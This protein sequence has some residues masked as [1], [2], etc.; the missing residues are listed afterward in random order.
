MG[1]PAPQVPAAF[2]H[3]VNSLL[4][5]PAPESDGQEQTAAPVPAQ[6]GAAPVPAPQLADAMIRSMLA[7]SGNVA[8]V[9]A[10]ASS[11]NAAASSSK[12]TPARPAQDSSTAQPDVQRAAPGAQTAPVIPPAMM[13]MIQSPLTRSTDSAAKN[14][15]KLPL[16]ASVIPRL[17]PKPS[18]AAPLAF[19]MRITPAAAPVAPEANEPASTPA[20][21]ESSP[22]QE[23]LTQAAAPAVA[24]TAPTVEAQTEPAPESPGQPAAS[25]VSGVDAKNQKDAQAHAE[26]V[27]VVTAPTAVSAAGDNTADLARQ[28]AVPMAN[29]APVTNSPKTQT[30]QAPS[31][32]QALRAAEPS[33]PA[34][35][36]QPSAPVKE[37]AVRIA[38]PESPAVDVHLAERGGQLHVA[39][40][41]ADG[42]LQTSLRQDL[43]TLVNSLE[44]S[45]Y[46]A[47]AFTPREGAPAAAAPAQM[48]FQNSRQDSETGSGGRHG[49]SGESSQNSGSGQQQATTARSAPAQMD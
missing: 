17:A 7:S 31:T 25:A 49:N 11:L 14:V 23:A 24:E 22:T 36:A 26:N 39:V 33:A 21:A 5:S 12:K 20:P 2:T 40:R 9:A 18:T 1:A 19:G 29:V 41:T 46:R 3:L 6:E 15:S 8:S 16:N 43:G 30:P 42:S 34:G 28:M 45:G 27:P 13:A 4:G 32:A 48:S 44:R 38:G 47:E 10:A 37:I 35:P